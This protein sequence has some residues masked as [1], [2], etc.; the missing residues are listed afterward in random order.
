MHLPTNNVNLQ[1]LFP[2]VRRLFDNSAVKFGRNAAK[3]LSNIP[4]VNWENFWSSLK[5]SGSSCEPLFDPTH[6]LHDINEK[7]DVFWTEN[8]L[9]RLVTVLLEVRS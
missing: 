4:D 7:I 5:I 8:S 2:D 9:W 1:F 6:S 3:T